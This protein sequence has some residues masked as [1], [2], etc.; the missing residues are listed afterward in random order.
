[1]KKTAL[2]AFASIALSVPS[3]ATNISVI[4][5]AGTVSNIVTSSTGVPMAT[6]AGRIRIGYFNTSA[7]SASWA[8]DLRSTNPALTNSALT[9]FVPLGESAGAPL[10][11]GA[12]TSTGPR[13]AQRTV[14]SVVQQGRLAG[15]ITSVSS[16]TGD[17]NSISASGVPAGTR[18][19]MLVY[20]DGADTILG[21]GEE[22]GVFSSDVW[23]MPAD[24]GL[25]LQ[26]NA[27]AV[28]LTG[29]IFRG[30]SGSLRL[31]PFIP[32]PSGAL[33]SLLAGLGLVARR[34][35]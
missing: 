19:Y 21:L 13:F 30:S 10:G 23:V 18:I 25:N 16:T 7:Q 22:F 15:Q 6:G 5:F 14:N 1:M 20:S 17:P 33:L 9:S 2:L 27:T 35:R 34:R 11:T 12:G 3:K 8:N 31:A 32:E 29:E 4:D 26:L 28:D 24:S